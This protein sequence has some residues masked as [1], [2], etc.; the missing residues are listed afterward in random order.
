[1]FI[2]RLFIFQATVFNEY[3]G[4]RVRLTGGDFFT[5]ERESFLNLTNATYA[6]GSM[7]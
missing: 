2:K 3:E 6:P 7:V 1:M 5:D 4:S